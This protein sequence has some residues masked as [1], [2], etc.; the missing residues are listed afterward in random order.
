MSGVL[1]LVLTL[2]LAPARAQVP[3]APVAPAG[4]PLPDGIPTATDR[5]E[6]VEPLWKGEAWFEERGV[7]RFDSRVV[8]LARASDGGGWL[9]GLEDGTLIRSMDGARTWSQVLRPAGEAAVTDDEAVL[10]DAESVAEESTA[11]QAEALDDATEESSSTPTNEEAETAAES[12]QEVN[13]SAPPDDLAGDPRLGQVELPN[14]GATVWFSEH[15]PGLALASRVD[16]LWRSLDAGVSWVRVDAEADARCFLALPESGTIL[17]GTGTGLRISPDSGERWIDA[18]DA[19]DGAAVASLGVV[20]REVVAATS[21]GLFASLDALRWR[22]LG[23]KESTTA[24]LGDPGWAGGMWVATG[25][26]VLRSDDGGA[27]FSTFSRQSL[28]GVTGLSALKGPAHLMAYGHDGAWET[29]D[30]AVTWHPVSTGLRDPDVRAAVVV[31]GRPI[32]ATSKALWRLRPVS[33]AAGGLGSRPK[34]VVT[35]SDQRMLGLLI[36]VSTERVGLDLERVQTRK[37]AAKAYLPRLT[38][39]A[40][41]LKY[42]GRESQFISGDTT[43]DGGFAWVISARACFGGCAAGAISD[44]IDAAD[45]Y[46]IAGMLESSEYDVVDPLSV[47]NDLVLDNQYVINGEVVGEDGE[48]LAAAN[49]AQKIRKY[50]FDV[51][52]QV[53][54]AWSALVRLRNTAA[55]ESLS[56][57]VDQILQVQELE[58]RL[59]LYTDGA[60]TRA[61]LM[62]PG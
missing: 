54:G 19:T 56:G 7:A 3:P 37:L 29:T 21:G 39:T 44:L 15:E 31:D 20:G 18:D 62:E 14:I 59:D 4:N 23:L 6:I 26:G 11:E 61:K 32:I 42:L 58:S 28:R 5:P 16:G 40:A 17:A 51:A 49:V 27:T 60:Y 45:E 10:L 12:P 38:L 2:L 13:E 9:A 43:E 36:E 46:G 48:A 24:V 1:P 57:S 55:P 33:F 25:R 30:G 41:A 35:E 34:P 8:S 52:D 47:I 22:A 50:R 53:A